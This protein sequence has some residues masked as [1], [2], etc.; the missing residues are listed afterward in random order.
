MDDRISTDT[1]DE[2]AMKTQSLDS[3]VEAEEIQVELYRRM[4]PRER[5]ERV[6]AANRAVREMARRRVLKMYGEDVSDREVK[7]RLASLWL[8]RETM[9]E[10]YDWDP[11]SEG[12]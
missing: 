5:L 6:A 3:G 8:D 2:A 1:R 9:I 11:E 7:L 4:S 12:Y 10:V